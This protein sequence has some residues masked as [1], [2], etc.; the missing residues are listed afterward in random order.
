[1]TDLSANDLTRVISQDP[2]IQDWLIDHL[3]LPPAPITVADRDPWADSLAPDLPTLMLNT[4]DDNGPLLIH[5]VVGTE[6]ALAEGGGRRALRRAVFMHEAASP[7]PHG[8][9]RVA[10]LAPQARLN[11]GVAEFDWHLTA[12]DFGQKLRAALAA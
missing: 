8:R 1:M 12:E 4:Q 2:L 11:D 9:F 3:G 6:T 10:V 5:V 7:A